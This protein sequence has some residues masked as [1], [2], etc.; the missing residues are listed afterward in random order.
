M[1][2]I[3]YLIILLFLITSCASKKN[4]SQPSYEFIEGSDLFYE[5]KMGDEEYDFNINMNQ[6]SEELIS[7]DWEMD[8]SRSGSIAIRSNELS[9]AMSLKNY[10][11]GGYKLLENQ[12]SVWVSKKLFNDL[13]SNK[14]VEIDLGNGQKEIFQKTTTELFPIINKT[15]EKDT[16]IKL[17]VFI[18]LDKLGKKEIWILDDPKNRLIV[19]MDLDFRIDLK[20]WKLID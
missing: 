16:P 14:A 12:T 5:V 19:M 18:I 15:N 6:F 13:K 2:K 10:F 3:I 11:S 8:M 7:F 4:L 17:P 9:N 1:K 20:S